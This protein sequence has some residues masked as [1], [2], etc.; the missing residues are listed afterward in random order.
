[1]SD[2]VRD[3]LRE[4]LEELGIQAPGQT[5]ANERAATALARYNRLLD[6]WNA[7]PGKTVYADQWLP[8]T[9]T[10]DLAPHTWGASGATWTIA[11]GP[12]RIHGARMFLDSTPDVASPIT[13]RDAAWWN[14][15]R[16]PDLSTS[17][18]TD[19]YPDYTWPNASLYFWPVP[20]TAYT[21]ELWTR[22]MLAQVTLNDSFTMPPGYRRAHVFSIAEECAD[23][24]GVQISDRLER[25]AMKARGVIY[26][27][28]AQ[29]RP[30]TTRD[31]GMPNRTRTKSY[32]YLTREGI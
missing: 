15:Q 23:A 29:R 3:I 13:L 4:A 16:V 1:M 14:N 31:A 24:F 18:P 30:L 21:V 19:L 6:A 20:A 26:G 8:Y 27:V 7:E 11:S 5:F 32:N 17:F 9:F 25:E 2:T 28:N 10:P 22:I 12:T